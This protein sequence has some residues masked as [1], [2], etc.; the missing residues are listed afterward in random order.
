S[1]LAT[2]PG[3][4]DLPGSVAY[5]TDMD[6]L[7]D[8]KL[9][10]DDRATIADDTYIGTDVWAALQGVKRTTVHTQVK[11]AADMRRQAGELDEQAAAKGVKTADR[12]A[13]RAE[14]EALRAKADRTMPFRDERVGQSPLWLMSTHRTF[15]ANRPGVG[16]GGGRPPTG[17]ARRV[18]TARLPIVCPCGCGYTITETDVREGRVKTGAGA[19]G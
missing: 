8:P 19:T 12:K 3:R 9:I 17:R 16:S 2:M 18:R 10:P 7:S 4:D 11:R 13:M 5:P 6:I 1:P 14:A 15:M